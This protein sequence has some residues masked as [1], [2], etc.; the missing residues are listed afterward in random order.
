MGVD[1]LGV[2]HIDHAPGVVVI[3]G[4]RSGGV[5][6]R[7][8][9]AVLVVG[10]AA[11]S[12]RAVGD[13]DRL[14]IGVDLDRTGDAFCGRDGNIATHQVIGEGRGLAGAIGAADEVAACVVTQRRD[15]PEPIGRGPDPAVA[16]VTDE[17]GDAIVDVGPHCGRAAEG[18]EIGLAAFVAEIGTLRA[19]QVRI[20]AR[21]QAAAAV[22]AI[23]EPGYCGSRSGRAAWSARAIGSRRRVGS[24]TFTQRI[25]GL[26]S[27][28]VQSRVGNVVGVVSEGAATKIVVDRLGSAIERTVGN[29]CNR[30]G[31]GRGHQTAAQ[32][33]QR[34]RRDPRAVDD[35]IGA[36]FEHVVAQFADLTSCVDLEA[37]LAVRVVIVDRLRTRRAGAVGGDLLDQA[38]GN[39]V[40]ILGAVSRIDVVDRCLAGAAAKRRQ[41]RAAHARELAGEPPLGIVAHGLGAVLA[42][43]AL[44]CALAE[45][46]PACVISETGG[47]GSAAERFDLRGDLSG[48]I[49]V[50]DRGLE[51][52]ARCGQ[53]R[54]GIGSARRDL[55]AAHHLI[56]VAAR[57]VVIARDVAFAIERR[58]Q[59]PAPV[60]DPV[61]VDV[62]CG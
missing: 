28:V 56:E 9:L 47:L 61:I 37:Q 13:Q 51:R 34:P 12:S 33:R 16:V 57:G 18:V 44:R 26:L 10:V 6:D 19:V 20:G 54:Q 43:H 46:P 40:D 5:G 1:A 53:A 2:D 17:R 29:G 11:G 21:L 15:I 27:D 24:E 23:G 30:T 31:Y 50:V 42:R 32:R 55:L 41:G 38:V 58:H 8:E 22:V 4:R 14:T 39:I 36:I 48:G 60:V 45:Q 25:I 3:A 7:L 52:A 49:A 35:R 59:P 62:V